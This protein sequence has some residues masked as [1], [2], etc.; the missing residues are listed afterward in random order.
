MKRANNMTIIDEGM[1]GRLTVGISGKS[2]L[3]EQ[4]NASINQSHDRE[5]RDEKSAATVHGWTLR[6]TFHF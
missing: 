4:L 6:A 2:W 1:W 3:N 5:E